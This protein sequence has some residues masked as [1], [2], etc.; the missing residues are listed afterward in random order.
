MDKHGKARQ[1]A[2]DNTIRCIRIASWISKYRHILRI[3]NTYC[4][5]RQQ[6]CERASMLRLH[7][8]F[9]SYR[10]LSIYVTPRA[11][12]LVQSRETTTYRARQKGRKCKWITAHRASANQIQ[13]AAA[14]E[15]VKAVIGQ[16]F[17]SKYG[18][19]VSRCNTRRSRLDIL[20]NRRNNR[21]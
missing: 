15:P 5:P 14:A 9:P 6:I 3:N 19:N 2:H 11:T 7:V 17:G 1:A 13:E 12:K 10:Y 20:A 16:V 21:C 8:Y 4:F 18:T